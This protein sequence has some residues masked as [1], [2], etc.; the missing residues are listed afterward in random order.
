MRY[1]NCSS[2]VELLTIGDQ[3]VASCPATPSGR[4]AHLWRSALTFAAA[5]V[6]GAAAPGS[7]EDL[8][9]VVETRPRVTGAAIR[10]DEQPACETDEQGQCIVSVRQFP[11][12]AYRAEV[13]FAGT[14]VADLTIEL[15]RDGLNF[16]SIPV[17]MPVPEDRPSAA[18]GEAAPK[19]TPAPASEAP[20]YRT[21][22]EVTYVVESNAL[23]ADVFVDGSRVTFTDTSG[24][25]VLTLVPGQL[26][27][28]SIRREGYEPAESRFAPQASDGYL[29]LDLK[30]ATVASG[31]VPTWLWGLIGLCAA[32][33]S[34]L[35]VLLVQRLREQDSGTGSFVPEHRTSASAVL[36]P[37]TF[38]RYQILDQIGEGG[39]ATIFRARETTGDSEVA[40][41][42]LDAKWLVDPEMVHKFLSEADALRAI[43]ARTPRAAVP[44][45]IR[46]GREGERADGRPFLALELVHG[47]GLD[48]LLSRRG[49]L[50]ESEVVGLG[51]QVARALHAAHEAGIVH[52]DLTPDNVLLAAGPAQV[53]ELLAPHIPRAILID[54]GVARQ[55]Q[56]ARVT[57]DGSIAG[58]PPY[59]SPEQCRGH[60]VDF[61]SDLYS[62]GILLFALLSGAPPFRSRNPFEVMRAH[63][64]QA[65]PSLLGSG[66]LE[67]F[68]RLIDQ[69][70]AKDPSERPASAAFVAAHLESFFAR[71]WSMSPI[72]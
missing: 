60:R 4:R 5:L 57:M 51:A 33:L 34:G 27:T 42:V 68:A 25:A 22:S 72:A 24:R 31:E 67:P 69:L 20:A 59:M 30:A 18:H 7:S 10:F 49:R 52:R 39:V 13:E 46:S 53:G 71:T 50:S 56:L 47:E 3:T 16:V 29:R 23:N 28:I 19:S 63:E 12:R 45:L 15:G 54:F 62:L 2:A 14:L 40:L 9:W 21:S 1:G 17:T 38:D 58:K 44:Q 37:S 35:G 66:I 36:L 41:K 26:T 8:D 11:A 48:R 32:G 61:R 70:L 65:P 55:E 43:H 64:H 6:A